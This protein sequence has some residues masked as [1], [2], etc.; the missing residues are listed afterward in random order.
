V[1]IGTYLQKKTTNGFFLL[2]SLFQNMDTEK[3]DLFLLVLFDEGK[4]VPTP[5]HAINFLT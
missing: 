4:K 5:T 1:S 2:F 3:T